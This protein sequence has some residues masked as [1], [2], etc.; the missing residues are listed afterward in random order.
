MK[1]TGKQ[2]AALQV[3]IGTNQARLLPEKKTPSVHAQTF[4]LAAWLFF[5]EQGEKPARCTCMQ[6]LRC[7]S[8]RTLANTCAHCSLIILLHAAG[9][10]WTVWCTID[11]ISD[12][13]A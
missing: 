1:S 4:A 13:Q 2:N 10:M 7:V 11:L 3:T 6:R 9:G 8:F 12:K 5:V